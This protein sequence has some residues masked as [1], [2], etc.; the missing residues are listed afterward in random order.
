MAGTGVQLIFTGA[1]WF[2]NVLLELESV[3]TALTYI[4]TKCITT[5]QA[6][7][8]RACTTLCQQK[9]KEIMSFSARQKHHEYCQLAEH[10][11]TFSR[12]ALMFLMNNKKK[13]KHI[14][15]I[16]YPRINALL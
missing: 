12:I 10:L 6:G 15:N 5:I 4:S 2:S 16:F 8:I 11:Y 1:N 3:G 13:T 9:T 14:Y 7:K